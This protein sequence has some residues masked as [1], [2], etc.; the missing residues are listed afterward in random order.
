MSFLRT[1]SCAIGFVALVFVA[2]LGLQ[3]IYTPAAEAGCTTT[4]VCRRVGNHQSC[5]T[6]TSCSSPRIRRCQLMNRCTPQ[7]TCVTRYGQTTCMT[8]DV[9]RRVEVCS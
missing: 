1:W 4:S 2:L 3:A 7:R 8:R 6:S 5:R 9:C